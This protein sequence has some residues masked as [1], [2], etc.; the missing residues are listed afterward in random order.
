MI[1]KIYTNHSDSYDDADHKATTTKTI[2]PTLVI[3]LTLLAFGR[4]GP[5]GLI[6]L[7]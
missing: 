6:L 7:T 2:A 4:K 3:V 1:T 5:Q